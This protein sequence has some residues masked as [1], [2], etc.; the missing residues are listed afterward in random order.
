MR[1]AAILILLLSACGKAPVPAT[2]STYS[3]TGNYST[4][5][6][7]D[8]P[9][10]ETVCGASLTIDKGQVTDTDTGAIIPNGSYSTGGFEEN[11]FVIP[12]CNYT[13]LDGQVCLQGQ[14]CAGWI[15]SS[16]CQAGP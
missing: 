14:P 3:F 7:P 9:L 6:T 2:H 1:R 10:V 4:A 12:P 5:P 8:V 16:C 11:G 15:H 13:V